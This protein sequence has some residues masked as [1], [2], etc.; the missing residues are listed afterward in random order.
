MNCRDMDAYLTSH[1]LASLP[2]SVSEHLS[3][4]DGCRRLYDS[5]QAIP[6]SDDARAHNIVVNSAIL[7]DLAAV[8]PLPSDNALAIICMVCAALVGL[9]GVVI[10]GTAGWQA[11]TPVLRILVFASILVCLVASAVGVV[12]EMTPGSK[13]P[14]YA[15]TLL[16]CG[17]VVFAGMVAIAFHRAYD[18][19]AVRVGVGCFLRGLVASGASAM[20]V[21]VALRR[22]VWFNRLASSMWIASLCGSIALLVLT[23]FC[24]VLAMSH[25]FLSHV[26]SIGTVLLLG[27]LI[28]MWLRSRNLRA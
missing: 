12:V 17:F 26:A 10:W 1:P 15:V 25:V 28:G 24:P 14:T 5:F 19:D 21:L 9:L 13:R 3:G 27:W 16:F 22:G 6:R 2:P 7:A 20:L 23:L 4:C 8:K 18:I 11:Q